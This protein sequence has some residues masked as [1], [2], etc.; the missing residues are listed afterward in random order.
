ML[1]R[2]LCTHSVALAMSNCPC[3]TRRFR[4]NSKAGSACTS[5]GRFREPVAFDDM[6]TGQE[7]QRALR[8][9]S[10]W[11]VHALCHMARRL[12]PSLVISER[13]LLSPLAATAQARCP[14]RLPP[15]HQRPC[16]A[17]SVSSKRAA[18]CTGHPRRACGPGRPGADRPAAGGHARVRRPPG[19]AR[20]APAAAVLPGGSPPSAPS[21]QL[22]GNVQQP[23]RRQAPAG[24]AAAAAVCRAARGDCRPGRGAGGYLHD[25]P[26]AAP[27]GPGGA[28][29]GDAAGARAPG[30]AP[31]R[32]AAAGARAP[33]AALRGRA[34]CDAR[35][36]ALACMGGRLQHAP[37]I[38]ARKCLC[39][40]ARAGNESATCAGAGAHPRRPPALGVRAVARGAAARRARAPGQHARRARR[41]ARQPRRRARAPRSASAM[42]AAPARRWRRRTAAL[43][44]AHVLCN[45]SQLCALQ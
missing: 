11:L 38:G 21:C 18:P 24:G 25:P 1:R 3:A 10:A 17:V 32:A 6:L 23:S 45:G 12:S 5:Q 31:G 37:C 19:R 20:C 30:A 43:A 35:C 44:A 28:A 34:V 13:S 27:A 7:F 41:G 40:I 29:A 8:L 4:S 33:R 16:L 39:S 42:T 26:V 15:Q 14:P 22:A 9:P 36:L 2:G